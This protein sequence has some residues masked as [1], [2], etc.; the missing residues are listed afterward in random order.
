VGKYY[1]SA[2][3]NWIPYDVQHPF[4]TA[5]CPTKIMDGLASGRPLLSTAVPECLLY[6]EYITVFR[7]PEEA[8][9]LIAQYLESS[10]QGEWIKRRASQI[11]FARRHLWSE[12]AA[13]LSTWLQSLSAD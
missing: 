2:A 5:S 12:R 7:S 6:P 3:L 11:A 4:N 9:T 10:A 13:T 8:K 1:W